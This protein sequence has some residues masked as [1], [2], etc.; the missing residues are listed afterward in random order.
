MLLIMCLGDLLLVAN[1]SYCGFNSTTNQFLEAFI[2]DTQPYPLPALGVRG[3]RG[4]G[5]FTVGFGMVILCTKSQV[6]PK[7]QIN[8]YFFLVIELFIYIYTYIY[9]YPMFIYKWTFHVLF[10]LT[11]S[12]SSSSIF[13]YVLL[14]ATT[15]VPKRSR[16]AGS[17]R[18]AHCYRW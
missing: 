7:K 2:L 5:C 4:L 18:F 16:P 13:Q 17:L 8:R 3:V 9:M 14:V 15:V 10:Y 11:V 1:G 6:P 12:P